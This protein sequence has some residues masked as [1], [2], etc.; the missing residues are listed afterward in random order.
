VANQNGPLTE[1]RKRE[2]RDLVADIERIEDDI[3][4]LT[5]QRTETLSCAK[6]AGWD[7]KA[8]K[9][10]VRRRRME[11]DARQQFELFQDAV[12]TYELAMLSHELKRDRPFAPPLDAHAY[13]EDGILVCNQGPAC[14][15]QAHQSQADRKMLAIA[16][17]LGDAI[18][19]E[20]K[21]S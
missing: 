1:A 5:V 10:L 21:P 7:V 15:C 13:D 6:E 20:R 19:T 18:T 8:I 4:L 11:P 12:T 14:T 3:D 17:Q 9:E 16:E 2:L